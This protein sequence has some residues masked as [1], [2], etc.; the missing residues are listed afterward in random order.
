MVP[1]GQSFQDGYA[2]VF[3]FQVELSSSLH[4]S[5]S[6]VMEDDLGFTVLPWVL[7]FW[8]LGSGRQKGR[9]DS[10]S[11]EAEPTP[12]LSFP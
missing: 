12:A 6:P 8:N 9:L 5:V 2:G 1:P 7:G 10:G 4:A 11:L 3:H